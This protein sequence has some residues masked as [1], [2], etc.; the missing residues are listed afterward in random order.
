MLNRVSAQPGLTSRYAGLLQ[1]NV[2]RADV[3]Y[4]AVESLRVPAGAVVA[5]T[6]IDGGAQA[7][8][9]ALADD[10]AT[11]GVTTLEGSA[12]ASIP[13]D[14]S[15][16][17]SRMLEALTNAR[18]G[19][20]ADA[21]GLLIFDP[22]TAA[23]ES[24]I[25]RMPQAARIFVAAP[26]RPGFIE[27]GG[28][29]AFRVEIKLPDV[30]ANDISLPDPLGKVVDEW[31]IPRGTATA[32][33]LQ[34]GQF[35]QIIDV[36]GQQCSDFMAMRSEAL[37]KGVERFIDSTVSRTMARSAYPLPGLHDKFY[38]QD[39]RPL[40]AVRQDTVGRHDT[41]ALAC[42]AR[43]Y[44]ERGFPGHLN[45]SDNISDA[46]APYGIGRRAA[47]PAINLFFN[48]WIAP[49]DHAIAS[50]EAWSRPG[51]YVAMQAMSDLVCVSTAC[52]DDVDPINGWNPTD[53]HIR[54]YEET[55]TIT[56]A[57]AWRANPEDAAKMTAHS[58]FHPRTSKLTSSYHVAR[59]LWMPAHFDATGAVEEY[60]ACK[61]AATL[62]DMSGLRKFD[63]VGPDAV[64]LLQHCL[65][66]DV[67]K[68]SV[69]RGFYAL[70]CD[71][72]GSVLDD[73]T[74]FRLE[75]TAFRWCCGSDHSALHLREQAEALGL[76]ARVLSLGGRMVNLALQGPKSRDI[77]REVV[78]TQP[79]RPSLDNLKWFGFTIARLH[80]RDG[81]MFMLCRSGF[82]GELGYEL[83]CDRDD[84]LTIW[85]GLMA[86][87]APEGLVP[88][89]GQALD[90][91][92][93][94]AGLM[95]AGAEFG[96]DADAMESGL[97][98]AVDFKK[99]DFI[100]RAAL[101]RNA[102]AT[103]RKLVGL[104]LAGN[105]VPHHGDGIFVGREQVGTITSGTYSPQ[106]G[107]AIAMARI[108][109]ENAAPG[110]E[111]EV[112]KLDGHMKRLAAKVVD[113]PFLDPK[114]EKARA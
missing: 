10:A 88:M 56:H 34:K 79:S 4:G 112:G 15:G 6:Q 8:V 2:L 59:D 100:G 99:P 43:G 70:M 92:R 13:L 75:D 14:S 65:T 16:F 93:I 21:R 107:H 19:A 28:G 42:T 49:A 96:P 90:M 114:R 25:F 54:I 60:W 17:D 5:I 110:A 40:L 109:V 57:V 74:L 26:V 94:E 33:E 41:F 55:S 48:S 31:R 104:H 98:F 1:P 84:A 76:N 105:E 18:G 111:L 46:F 37:D 91:L 68:L 23:G 97:G 9:T 82:T 47:W 95:I 22:M 85:D 39:I 78:F 89:G 52:P 83:F 77:L 51:D 73:G 103:R 29:G 102:A 86:A 106:M 71:A 101:E 80:D 67:S 69:H 81:P 87:G 72:R 64:A 63:I 32:Y 36:E 35:V 11:L 20:L 12:A 108:A 24:H 30:A 61:K 3:G 45:C 7:W 50:D 27:T 53:I 62:Q 44:E 66:R 38:D 58:A 113:L